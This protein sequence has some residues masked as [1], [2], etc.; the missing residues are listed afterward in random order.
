MPN[1]FSSVHIFWQPSWNDDVINYDVTGGGPMEAPIVELSV[2][3]CTQI[4]S[5]LED[6]HKNVKNHSLWLLH[7]RLL[8]KNMQFIKT[9]PLTLAFLF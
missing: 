2:P 8:E 6:I 3:S 9:C 7:C 1:I 4:D 5:T